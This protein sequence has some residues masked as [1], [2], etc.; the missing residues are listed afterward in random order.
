[1]KVGIVLYSH[2]PEVVW[3]AFRF[4]NFTIAMG[5]EVKFFLVGNGVD[6]VASEALDTG[7]FKPSE[8]LKTVLRTGGKFFA[9]GTCLEMRKLKAP[10]AFTV[11][12]LKE[13]YKIVT[14]S[15]RVLT[16]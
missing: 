10:P 6:C 7:K 14:E 5:D 2:D 12:T 15:D 8:Q 16:F 11:G 13:M 4:A 3:N 9:C 1:M